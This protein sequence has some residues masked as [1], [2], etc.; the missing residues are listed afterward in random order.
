MIY[1][2]VLVDHPALGVMLNVSTESGTLERIIVCS[3]DYKAH[4][5]KPGKTRSVNFIRRTT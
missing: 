1:V 2:E 4:F 3:E 5:V